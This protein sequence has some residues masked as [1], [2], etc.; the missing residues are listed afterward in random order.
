VTKSRKFDPPNRIIINTLAWRSAS[1]PHADSQVTHTTEKQSRTNPLRG[2]IG[3][4]GG[5]GHWPIHHKGSS[6]F[7]M[8][9]P[10]HECDRLPMSL[11]SLPLSGA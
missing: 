7:V 5:S 9:K 3:K 11:L 2:E 4:K 1:G 8:A 10:S 6:H